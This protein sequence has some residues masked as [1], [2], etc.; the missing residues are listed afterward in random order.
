MEQPTQQWLEQ[1]DA[2]ESS[3]PCDCDC[4]APLWAYRSYVFGETLYLKATGVDM[5]HA[6]QQSTLGGPGPV[7][8]GR[9]GVVDPLFTTGFRTGFVKAIDDR[10]SVGMTYTNYH[11]HATDT[12][13]A[14][15]EPGGTVSSLVLHP[16]SLAAGSTSSQVSAGYDIDFQL[17]DLDYRRLLAGGML[18]AVNYT[19]G[20]RYAKLSQQ[21]QQIGD[22]SPPAA[23]LQ[24][25]TNITFEGVGFRTGFDG[26]RRIANSRLSAYAKGFISVLFG[27]FHSNYS[28]LDATTGS[29]EAASNW[30]NDRV[31]PILDYEV[32]INWTSSN[33]RWVMATGYYT[34][35]WFNAVTTPQFVPAVQT[36]N[37]ANLGQTIAFDG[38]VSRL[39]FRF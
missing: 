2:A 9:V 8:D 31:L 11:S 16:N 6:I 10:S 24:T 14:A 20:V 30:A 36:S 23:T 17:V 26:Q 32:G 37:F 4:S 38:L 15:N 22:F 5:S 39:E 3:C 13:P 25:S 34:A 28:Q 19:A 21:F 12:L 35:F 7:P 18:G 1:A 27:H 29:V 33:G